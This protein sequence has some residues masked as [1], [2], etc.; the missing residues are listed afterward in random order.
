MEALLRQPFPT[1]DEA[2]TWLMAW[3]PYASGR[4]YR[5]RVGR[6]ISASHGGVVAWI[7]V[8]WPGLPV[9]ACTAEPTGNPCARPA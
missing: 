7:W 1:W 8:S 4:R 5:G 2:E 9:P 3:Q 6:C